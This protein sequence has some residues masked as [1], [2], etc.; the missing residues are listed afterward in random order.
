MTD[1]EPDCPKCGKEMERRENMYALDGMF[2]SGLVCCGS[3]WSENDID[4]EGFGKF[5]EYARER[6]KRRM[7][8]ENGS[9]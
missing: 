4:S 5:M 2:F 8:G 7:E 3:L 6:H 9:S 1:K